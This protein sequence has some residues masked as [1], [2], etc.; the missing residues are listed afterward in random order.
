MRNLLLLILLPVLIACNNSSENSQ[1]ADTSAEKAEMPMFTPPDIFCY[2]NVFPY[3]D[4]SGL[5]DVEEMTLIIMDDIVTGVLAT[6]PA[7]KYSRK[8]KLTG[9]RKDGIL[10]LSYVFVQE[11]ILD[12]G[13]IRVTLTKDAAVISSKD[14][15]FRTPDK[16]NKI[17]CDQ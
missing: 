9:V 7:K 1:Q 3:T 14:P 4:G 2:Q 10:D 6:M 8:G 11:G 5:K 16:I 15:D 17:P 12:T 13:R